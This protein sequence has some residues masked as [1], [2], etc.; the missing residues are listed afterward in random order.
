VWLQSIANVNP[1]SGLQCPS[2][3][4]ARPTNITNHSLAQLH[5][6]TTGMTT[7]QPPAKQG[8]LF[9][10]G[11]LSGLVADG[12]VHPIDTIRARLQVQRSRHVDPGHYRTATQAFWSILRLEGPGSLYRGFGAVA[13]G[14]VPGHALYFAGYETCKDTLL[15]KGCDQPHDKVYEVASHLTS[16]FVADIFGSLVWTPMDVV[17]QRLQVFRASAASHSGSAPQATNSYP[18]SATVF[19]SILREEGPFGLYKGFMAGL[20]TYGPYVSLYF[21]MYEQWKIVFS[22]SQSLF[23]HVNP[24]YDYAKGDA[25]KLPSYM[26]LSGAALS[27]AISAAVTCPLDV[28]KTRIQTQRSPSQSPLTSTTTITTTSPYRGVGNA[29]RSIIREE[30]LGA[31]FSGVK[32]RSLWMASGTALTMVTYEE[33]KRIL[34]I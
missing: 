15:P 22:Q 19:A 3:C 7:E 31:L 4:I 30:G 6:G 26:Y 24:F 32:P 34:S 21:A 28:V 12:V 25:M 20:M 13:C 14:T 16:G 23:G 11:A 8:K 5:F 1:A 29:I 18:N 9:F 17:K 33:V 27:G 10:A 2:F